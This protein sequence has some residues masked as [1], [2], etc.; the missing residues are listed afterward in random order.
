MSAQFRGVPG[1]STGDPKATHKFTSS[2]GLDNTPYE[3]IAEHPPALKVSI[4]IAELLWGVFT[5]VVQVTTST[6]GVMSM[7]LTGSAVALANVGTLAKLY[8]WAFTL[9]FIIAGGIQIVLHMNAQSL[10]STWDRLR[11]IQNFNIKSNHALAS[12]SSTITFR[13][14][15]CG[16]ALIADIVSDATFVNLYTHNGFVILMWIVFLTG[17]ST[18][19]L[20]DGATR[21]WGA[22]EDFKDYQAYHEKYD[23]K[24][25]GV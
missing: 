18:I 9:A 13:T 11:H 5:N 17:S 1:G 10:S 24:P 22:I 4:G 19:V 8:P 12:V 14:A 7:V 25:K 15:L 23:V 2:E 20:Y 6:I 16:L 21:I 3:A